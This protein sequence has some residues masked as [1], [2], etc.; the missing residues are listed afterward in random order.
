[1]E[2]F[3]LNDGS[4]LISLRVVDSNGSINEVTETIIVE[5]KRMP[6]VS[7]SE[8]SGIDYFYS[9]TGM[10]VRDTD[11]LVRK[12]VPSLQTVL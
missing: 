2:T 3:F 4:N 10:V 7:I 1:M 9:G 11:F 6:A 12:F 5:D 8:F